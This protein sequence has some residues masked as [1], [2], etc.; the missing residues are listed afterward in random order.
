MACGRKPPIVIINVD[1]IKPRHTFPELELDPDN[2]QVLC[3]D[4]NLGKGCKYKDDL[5]PK[6]N[7]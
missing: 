6:E 7:K 3:A 2:L 1:H 4:C 5:R